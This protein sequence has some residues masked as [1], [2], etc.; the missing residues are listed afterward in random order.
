MFGPKGLKA[1]AE[2][3]V[4]IDLCDSTRLTDIRERWRGRTDRVFSRDELEAFPGSAIAI[5]W[6]AREAVVKALGV[7]GMLGSPLVEMC[8]HR[9]AKG[10]LRYAPGPRARAVM[11]AASVAEISLHHTTIADVILVIALAQREPQGIALGPQ[12]VVWGCLPAGDDPSRN[13]RRAL[14]Q[15]IAPFTAATTRFIWGRGNGQAPRL[16]TSEGA[17]ISNV[18]LTNDGGLAAGIAALPA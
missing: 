11:K 15:A 8:V 16:E 17:T 10:T 14:E 3:G 18:S 13:A 7:P 4:G 12:R 6:A 2:V 9:T 1:K 5:P